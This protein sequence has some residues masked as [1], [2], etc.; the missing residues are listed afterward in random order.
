[1]G[2]ELTDAEVDVD[3]AHLLDAGRLAAEEPAD[4]VRYGRGD[5]AAA[6]FGFDTIAAFLARHL[7]APG[8][9]ASIQPAAGAR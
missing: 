1:M 9:P 6:T 4:A 7:I 3:A 5:P 2:R 8:D